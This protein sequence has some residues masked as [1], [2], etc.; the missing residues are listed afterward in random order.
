MLHI[1]LDQTL[2]HR[3]RDSAKVGLAAA[4]QAEKTKKMLSPDGDLQV[5]SGRPADNDRAV[6]HRPVGTEGIS[7]VP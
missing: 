1:L 6:G 5:T 4:V 3:I 7:V 2:F